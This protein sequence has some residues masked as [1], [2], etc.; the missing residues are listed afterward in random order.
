MFDKLIDLFKFIVKNWR[1][2]VPILAFC[3]ISGYM[4]YA[5]QKPLEINK[6]LI[7]Q[8]EPAHEIIPPITKAIREQ[9]ITCGEICDRK[10]KDH[11]KRLHFE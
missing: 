10:I 1:L 7:E 11:E 5:P 4:V 8:I 2:I 3:G 6:P 9:C